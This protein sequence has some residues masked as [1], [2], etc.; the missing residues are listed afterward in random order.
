V[1]A[2][3]HK[4]LSALIHKGS[5]YF[6]ES[7]QGYALPSDLLLVTILSL[8]GASILTVKYLH[9]QTLL[10]DVARVKS[11]YA[12]PSG[13]SR[14][15]ADWNRLQRLPSLGKDIKQEIVFADQSMAACRI[16]RT[17]NGLYVS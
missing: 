8:T 17:A 11:D 2:I 1:D 12:A 6:I 15:A 14:M 4:S 5:K 10:M 13:I 16:F 9:Q 7:S 3:N